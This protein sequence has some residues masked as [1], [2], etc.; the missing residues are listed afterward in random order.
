MTARSQDLHTRLK[1]VKKE[2]N[3]TATW[4]FLSK[5]VMAP[6]RLVAL[7][8]LG[9]RYA[10]WRVMLQPLRKIFGFVLQFPATYGIDRLAAQRRQPNR[11][12]KPSPKRTNSLCGTFW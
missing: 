2:T 4:L 1:K 5:S 10:E 6:T 11:N 8:G 7:R 12:P 3:M 9:E